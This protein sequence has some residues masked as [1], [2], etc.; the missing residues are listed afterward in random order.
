MP[1]TTSKPIPTTAASPPKSAFPPPLDLTNKSWRTLDKGDGAAILRK[2]ESQSKITRSISPPQSAFP[3]PIKQG[4]KRQRDYHRSL[5][6]NS[7]ESSSTISSTPS[8]QKKEN[9]SLNLNI[10]DDEFAYLAHI[11]LNHFE[12][13]SSQASTRASC[14]E[15]SSSVFSDVFQYFGTSG[16]S[17]RDDTSDENDLMI[18]TPDRL[19]EF[20]L[21]LKYRLRQ[22]API[23]SREEDSITTLTRQVART[24]SMNG[25][26]SPYKGSARIIT[27]AS[28][29]SSTSSKRNRSQ[30]RNRNSESQN[31][32]SRD[33]KALG[34][35]LKQPRNQKSIVSESFEEIIITP[36]DDKKKNDSRI[37][38]SSKLARSTE[39]YITSSTAT[40]AIPSAASARD[41]SHPFAAKTS[42]TVMVETVEEYSDINS[43]DQSSSIVSISQG[44]DVYVAS[45]NFMDRD[46]VDPET[47]ENNNDF[48]QNS[49][50]SLTKKSFERVIDENSF[51]SSSNLYFSDGQT[52]ETASSIPSSHLSRRSPSAGSPEHIRQQYQL[53]QEQQTARIY[54]VGDQ[55][56]DLEQ[57]Y[58]LQGE[59]AY[60]Q[61]QRQQEQQIAEIYQVEDQYYDMEHKHDLQEQR[62]DD[63]EPVFEIIEEPEQAI[64]ETFFE[65]EANSY[66][67][68]LTVEAYDSHYT[69]DTGE[70]AGIDRTFEE[71]TLVIKE[72]VIGHKL[73][74]NPKLDSQPEFFYEASMAKQNGVGKGNEHPTMDQNQTRTMDSVNTWSS[75]AE[76]KKGLMNRDINENLRSTPYMANQESSR[77][78]PR[79]SRKEK[80]EGHLI[81]PHRHPEPQSK[82][83]ADGKKQNINNEI[84]HVEDMMKKTTNPAVQIACEDQLRVLRKK[85]TNIDEERYYQPEECR[86]SKQ[87]IMSDQLHRNANLGRVSTWI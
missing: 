20:K 84:A 63:E 12:S 76:S 7:S 43:T 75:V 87:K 25:F 28:L 8:K 50:S 34:K 57:D 73:P 77:Q 85:S 6:N 17:K 61:F 42:N 13:S 58:P 54:Q 81:A 37:K 64:L 41:N 21:A 24:V 71:E 65:R 29:D 70:F 14:N 31:S 44:T 40:P 4:S 52:H 82:L 22:I 38:P 79:L 86:I 66:H 78:S 15:G 33:S 69:G 55:Y 59:Q 62:E 9:S 11:I 45:A 19:E 23:E 35:T 72:N 26:P 53:Q 30:D 60:Q 32:S 80:E 68:E 36:S 49:S 2:N 3:P 5:V 51:K 74:L 39:S 18:L 10:N 47:A 56:C 27:K 48:S 67:T 1:I 46:I 83:N 16:G